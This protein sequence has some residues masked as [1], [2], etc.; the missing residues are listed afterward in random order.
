MT[1]KGEGRE[2]VWELRGLGFLPL[3]VS[4]LALRQVLPLYPKDRVTHSLSH[5]P[6]PE[7]IGAPD[8][9][10]I[11]VFSVLPARRG[12]VSAC[13]AGTTLPPLA[14]PV[15]GGSVR[16]FLLPVPS[17]GGRGLA[18]PLI[19]P[20]QAERRGYAN[21]LLTAKDTLAFPEQGFTSRQTAGPDRDTVW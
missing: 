21:C 12:A 15:P 14:Q 17:P 10:R 3:L 11:A 1:Q 16:G 4:L 13:A 19:S 7:S 20:S 8:S 2:E 18:T 9:G 6:P 5:L